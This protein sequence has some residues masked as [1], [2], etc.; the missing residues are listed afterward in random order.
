MK[1]ILV[2]DWHSELHEAP[3]EKSL[4]S[5]GHRVV[6]FKWHT[7]FKIGNNHPNIYQKFQNKYLFGPTIQKINRD[8]IELVISEQ[9]CTLFI[10]RGTHIHPKTLIEIKKCNP[11]ILIVGYNN[12]DPFSLGYPKWLWRHFLKGLCHYDIVFAYRHKNLKEFKEAGASNVHLLRSWFDPER[13]YPLALGSQP[14]SDYGCDVIF[15]GHYEDDGRLEVLEEVV[16]RGWKLKLYGPGYEWDDVIGRSHYLKHLAPVSLVWGKE[17]NDALCNTKIALCFLSKINNDTY[18]RRCFEIPAC[19]TVLMSER[20]SDLLDLYREDEEALFFEGL[21]EFGNKL[22]RFL[23]N[24]ERLNRIGKNGLR[25]VWQDGHDIE[26]RMKFLISKIENEK[27]VK[28]DDF[29]DIK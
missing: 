10:Y 27:K 8:I 15:I 29:A 24:P 13:N 23:A 6:C 2:G 12:D 7:Y 26:T 20:T 9:P 1:I 25:R 28:N 18:T 4:K 11:N 14:H 22:D 16:K 21:H 17:Y 5:L 19:G 3:M